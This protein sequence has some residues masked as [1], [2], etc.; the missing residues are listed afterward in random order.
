LESQVS[1][2][3]TKKVDT[4]KM[5]TT[6]SKKQ[7]LVKKDTDLWKAYDFLFPGGKLSK[8]IKIFNIYKKNLPID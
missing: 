1:K 4:P 6:K 7:L 8:L 2:A 5:S 3:T